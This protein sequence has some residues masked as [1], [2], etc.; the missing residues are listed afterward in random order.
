MKSKDS[1]WFNSATNYLSVTKEA[2]QCKLAACSYMMRQGQSGSLQSE[3]A[4][5][6]LNPDDAVALDQGITLVVKEGL[7]EQYA[8][9]LD[10]VSVSPKLQELTVDLKGAGLKGLYRNV[11]YAYST[12]RAK[13]CNVITR[14]SNH[15]Q[16]RLFLHSRSTS[17][18]VETKNYISHTCNINPQFMHYTF[19]I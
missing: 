10:A 11:L 16:T 1:E 12:D 9:E 18:A 8:S 2:L 7:H 14:R 3:A 5:I 15:C 19:T 13:S 4:S 6:L 17:S